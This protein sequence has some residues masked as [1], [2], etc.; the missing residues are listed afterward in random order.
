M[1][2]IL[3]FGS[4]NFDKIYA[5]THIVQPGETLSSLELNIR[6]GGK[7]YNQAVAARQSGAEVWLAGM[8]GEDGQP[9]IDAC[10][11]MGIHTDYLEKK[12]SSKTGHAI[13]QVNQEAENSILLYGGANQELTQEYIDRVLSHFGKE[14]FI[15]LQNEINSMEYIIEKAHDLGMNIVLNPSPFDEKIKNCDFRKVSWL[16]VNEIEARQ[17]VGDHPESDL[18]EDLYFKYPTSNIILTLGGNGA[19]CYMRE[20]RFHQKAFTVKPIDTTGAGDCFTGYFLGLLTD[21]HSGRKALR[22]SAAAAALC[23]TKNGAAESIPTINEVINFI[24]NSGAK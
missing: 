22:V 13:I 14:D 16:F 3:V 18:I 4:F 1:N 12:E 7:G 24:K 19:D 8:V 10:N 21:T 9:F 5:V 20:T 17:I 23:I 2:R 11:R 6:L 15:L